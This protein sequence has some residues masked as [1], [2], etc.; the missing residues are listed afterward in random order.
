MHVHNGQNSGI[1]WFHH[2]LRKNGD[3]SIG[4]EKTKS[5]WEK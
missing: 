2:W 3:L 1:S 4:S 5:V